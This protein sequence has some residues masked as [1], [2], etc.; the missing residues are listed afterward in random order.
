MGLQNRLQNLTT[1]YE[2]MQNELIVK[3][4]Y[5]KPAVLEIAYEMTFNKQVEDKK[6]IKIIND[7]ISFITFNEFAIVNK[8]DEYDLVNYN[9]KIENQ[10][11]NII[12][13]DDDDD[14]FRFDDDK[15]NNDYYDDGLDMDQQSPEYWDSL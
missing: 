8:V 14:D 10:Q 2:F 6:N 4:M 3:F 7:F 12:D 9:S 15:S 11:I 13:Y 1:T 5:H